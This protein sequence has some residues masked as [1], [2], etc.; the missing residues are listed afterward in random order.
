MVADQ[1]AMVVWLDCTKLGRIS[2]KDLDQHMEM[3]ARTLGRRGAHS[4]GVVTA[5]ACTSERVGNALRA[6]AWC[7]LQTVWLCQSP[8]PTSLSPLT[9]LVCF[10]TKVRRFEDKMDMK[11][12]NNYAITLKMDSRPN[13]KKVPLVFPAWLVMEQSQE[14]NNCFKD[15]QLLLDRQ[16]EGVCQ[17]VWPVTF[18]IWTMHGVSWTSLDVTG[19]QLLWF[20]SCQNPSMWFLLKQMAFPTR[21]RETGQVCCAHV[22]NPQCDV[23]QLLSIA[24]WNSAW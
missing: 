14:E 18:Q 3:L 21:R 17:R 9:E 10:L 19:H 1:Y 8:L 7:L 20:L 22:R 6:E 11:G 23:F 5:P 13:S 24:L 16:R 2:A 15:C 4:I 12:L